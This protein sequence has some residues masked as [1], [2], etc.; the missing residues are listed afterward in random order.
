MCDDVENKSVY[1]RF[2]KIVVG[3]FKKK[4]C[5]FSI[6]C[7]NFAV[8]YVIMC[9][10]RNKGG[11]CVVSYMVKGKKKFSV[12]F[13]TVTSCISTAMVLILLGSATFFLMLANNF[14]KELR[15][16]FT[17]E[18]LLD[19]K[20]KEQ[21]R[22]SLEAKLA[23][24]PYVDSV[25]Y[26]SKEEGSA[27]LAK[28][29][30]GGPQ[31]FLGYNPIPAEFELF[32]KSDFA[33]ED[34]LLRY[35]PDLYNQSHVVDVIYPKDALSFIDRVIPRVGL[36]LLSVA[37]LLAFISFSL[38]HN[39]MRMSIYAHRLS[40][41]TMK[42]VG[43]RWSYIRRPFLFRAAC[44]GL[45]AAIFADFLLSIGIY[46]MLNLDTYMSTL[47]TSD[48]IYCTLGIGVVCGLTLTVVCAYVSV[49]KFLKMSAAEMFLK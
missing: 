20:I 22:T 10:A 24:L 7:R 2:F 35:V 5:S 14:G 1:L 15:S 12:K 11:A 19:D 36:V 31:E 23:L 34:S 13:N 43:A 42:L 16:N 48:V 32:L 18:V 29:L 28:A 41:R 39:T 30:D 3:F 44:I 40:I 38:I 27:E 9:P 21:E 46:A 8:I 37:V 47:I 49:N 45:F 26:I 6:K 4:N 33:N 25:H 17:V